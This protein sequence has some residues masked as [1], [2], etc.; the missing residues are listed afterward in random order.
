MAEK[1]GIE[2]KGRRGNGIAEGQRGR[3]R[4]ERG[5]ERYRSWGEF[6][7]VD[8]RY[9]GAG[10]KNERDIKKNIIPGPFVRPR[11]RG[12]RVSHLIKARREK[13][14]RDAEVLPL[15]LG[16]LAPRRSNYGDGQ[17][18]IEATAR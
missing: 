6:G 13:K 17:Q 9:Y 16:S 18:A 12:R 14:R 15:R 8:G 3:R 11:D 1:T 7:K 10:V 2:K 4:G 5:R